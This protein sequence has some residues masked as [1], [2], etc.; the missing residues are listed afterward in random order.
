MG[1]PYRTGPGDRRRAAAERVAASARE[2]ARMVAAVDLGADAVLLRTYFEAFCDE[3]TGRV[4]DRLARAASSQACPPRVWATR[5]KARLGMPE[6]MWTP[7]SSSV[8]CT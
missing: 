6:L 7:P 1:D 3:F 5:T 2:T 8:V 4:A